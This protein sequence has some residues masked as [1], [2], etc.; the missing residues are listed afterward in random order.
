MSHLRASLTQPSPSPLAMTSSWSSWSRRPRQPWTISG[1]CS[2]WSLTCA[3][4]AIPRL[5]T[6]APVR[7]AAASSPCSGGRPGQPPA[8]GLFA[9]LLPGL[10]AAI[11]LQEG[12]GDL[13]EPPWPGWLLATIETGGDGYCLHATMR[14]HPRTDALLRRLQALARRNARSQARSRDVVHYDLN[15]ANILHAGGRLPGV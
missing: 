1:G 13:A 7:P 8:A 12:A 14:Q 11:E 15:P 4:A 3:G 10:L 5:S 2:G 6:S 9:A